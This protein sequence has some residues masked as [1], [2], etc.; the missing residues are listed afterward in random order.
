LLCPVREHCEAAAAGVQEQIPAPRKAVEN[1]LLRRDVL[2][3]RRGQRWLIE[4][5]PST[6]RWAGMWQFVTVERGSA[7]EHGL[8]AR[9]QLGEVTHGLTHRRYEFRVF[10]GGI[11][12]R[13]GGK[14]A[15]TRAW[16]SLAELDRYPLPR[17]HVKVAQMLAAIAPTPARTHAPGRLRTAG[18]SG[19]R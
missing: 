13:N 15:K 1:P 10:N 18:T 16:V 7:A 3:I 2:C 19:R 4:Q 11:L 12:R 6:G 8:E 17:P 5:R 9:E 14:N